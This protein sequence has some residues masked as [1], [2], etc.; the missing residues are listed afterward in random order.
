M[1]QKSG[2]HQLR[3]VVDPIIY[4]G[5][6]TCQVVGNGISEPATVLHPV[7]ALL[8]PDVVCSGRVTVDRAAVKRAEV[9]PIL[10]S[11]RIVKCR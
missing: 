2:D 6:H 3:L 8:Q 10:H 4:D 7:F 11:Y 9:G 5:F 1:V